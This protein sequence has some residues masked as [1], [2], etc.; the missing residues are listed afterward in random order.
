MA[1]EHYFINTKKKMSL[2]NPDYVAYIEKRGKNGF[3]PLKLLSKD[4]TKS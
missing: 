2:K 1:L 3:D 4:K